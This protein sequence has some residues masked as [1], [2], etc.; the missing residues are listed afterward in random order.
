MFSFL[1]QDKYC[2]LYDIAN[3][4]GIIIGLLVGIL[5]W[6]LKPNIIFTINFGFFEGLYLSSPNYGLLIESTIP[7]EAQKRHSLISHFAQAIFA[8]IVITMFYLN[9]IYPKY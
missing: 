6:N 4:L 2:N 8:L 1:I 9:A 3:F 5:D 7:L